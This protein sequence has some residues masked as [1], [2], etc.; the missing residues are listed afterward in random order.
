[1]IA[2]RPSRRWIAGWF[3]LGVLASLGALATCSRG[4][5]AA[6][7]VAVFVTKARAVLAERD[8]R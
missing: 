4:C 2:S 5:F 6:D 3:T 1:M 7:P 8:A